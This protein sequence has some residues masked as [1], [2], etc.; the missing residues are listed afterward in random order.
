MI[1]RRSS[2]FTGAPVT[3][4]ISEILLLLFGTSP[5]SSGV[6]ALL[7]R[8]DLTG[9]NDLC[10]GSLG[11]WL[12]SGHRPLL[13]RNSRCAGDTVAPSGAWNVPLT[14]WPALAKDEAGGNL[15]GVQGGRQVLAMIPRTSGY[16]ARAS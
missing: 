5:A 4:V 16:V 11:S 7:H 10:L 6:M 8:S 2:L 13:P 12:V 15:S 9:G 14:S 1:A 3:T